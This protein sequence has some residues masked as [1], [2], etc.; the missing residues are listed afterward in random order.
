V[1]KGNPCPRAYYRCTGSPDCPVRKKLQRCAHD[2]SVLVSTYEGVHNHPLTPYAAA[3]ASAIAAAGADSSS[4][5][6]AP[7]SSSLR[8]GATDDAP[9][10]I[11][12]V[13]VAALPPPQSYYAAAANQMLLP[14][15]M[16]KAVADPKFRAAVMAAVASYV[17]ELL[18]FAPPC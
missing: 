12:A 14:N 16:E 17:G 1:A 11:M 13:P 18:T 4:S 9:P 10:P 15:I 6:A 7:P 2:A 3:M 8:P 5:S